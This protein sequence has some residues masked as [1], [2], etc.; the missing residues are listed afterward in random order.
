MLKESRYVRL[1][2]TMYRV[3][4]NS[5][6]PLF[7]HRKS[8][9]VFTMWQHV[10]LLAIRQYEGKS[11]RMFTE[12]LVEAYYLRLFLGLSRIPHF[13]TLQKF[14]DRINNSLLEK[15]ISSFIVISG[16]KH[17]FVGIDSTGFKITHAS[18]YYTDRTGLRRKYAKLSI[19]ADVLQQIICNIRIRRAPTR[20]D[21]IDFKPI[22]TKTSGILPVSVVA[23]DKGYDSEDNH[24]LVRENLHAFSII[25]ARYEHVP[26]WRTH[27]KYRKRMKRGYSKL[28]YNQRNK[29]ET[30]MSVIKRLFGEHIMSR[31]TRTQNRELLFR[32]ITYNMHRLTNLIILMMFSTKP[33]NTKFYMLSFYLLKCKLFP[34]EFRHII[35]L[36]IYCII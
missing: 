2:N 8:N 11:Y 24:L 36:Q 23:A 18:Q 29:D 4:R 33:E 31:L 25:P 12:W 28:L 1:A 16:T 6:I 22:I 35:I 7:L 30:I 14:T 27:G 17:I 34:S 9:H 20:H 5:R 13:T 32:C 26:I 21:N 19:G 10:I 3:L 15:I